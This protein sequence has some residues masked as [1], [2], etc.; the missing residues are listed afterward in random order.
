[1]LFAKISESTVFPNQNF[2]KYIHISLPTISI[3]KFLWKL[4]ILHRG[5]YM[6]AHVL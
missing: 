3:L 5:S 4:N 2:I 6:S 1:M